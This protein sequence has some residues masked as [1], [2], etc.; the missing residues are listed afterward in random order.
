MKQI[1][2]FWGGDESPVLII[3]LLK[4]SLQVLGSKKHTSVISYM[5]KI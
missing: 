4:G 3:A 1:A 5:S 2:Q